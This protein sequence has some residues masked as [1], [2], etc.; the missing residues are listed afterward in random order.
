MEF[1]SKR[2]WHIPPVIDLGIGDPDLPTPA[3]I[4]DKLIGCPEN[5]CRKQRG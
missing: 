2:V 1:M 3:P 5:G 4:V